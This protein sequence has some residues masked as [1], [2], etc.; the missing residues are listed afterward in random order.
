MTDAARRGDRAGGIYVL[1]TR[2][3]RFGLEIGS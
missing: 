3:V 2:K 1:M